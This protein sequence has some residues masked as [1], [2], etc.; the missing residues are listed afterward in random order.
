MRIQVVAYKSDFIAA[1]SLKNRQPLDLANLILPA[2]GQARFGNRSI[3]LF[4]A[5]CKL[6]INP[7]LSLRWTAILKSDQAG[8]VC[9]RSLSDL[10]E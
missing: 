5:L 10:R 3:G 8:A 9:F 1:V 4:N 2:P 7:G 6:V